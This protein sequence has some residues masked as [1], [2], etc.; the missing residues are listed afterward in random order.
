MKN[1]ATETY[2]YLMNT[3]LALALAL[4]LN[5]TFDFRAYGFHYYSQIVY[6]FSGV[7]NPII[8]T[9]INVFIIA[10]SLISFIISM[11]VI[12]RIKKLNQKQ[13]YSQPKLLFNIYAIPIVGFCFWV[14]A[15]ILKELDYHS[16]YPRGESVAV[17][18]PWALGQLLPDAEN[19]VDCVIYAVVQVR[20]MKEESRNGSLRSLPEVQKSNTIQEFFSSF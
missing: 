11:K 13:A 1:L 3:L 6:L 16:L 7:N 9:V 5:S 18:M 4:V 19:L 14:G 12:A 10:L 20:I 8:N 17:Q 2:F 15:F